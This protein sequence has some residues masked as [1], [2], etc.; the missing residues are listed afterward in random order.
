MA[1][2]HGGVPLL[3]AVSPVVFVMTRERTGAITVGFVM[4]ARA[5]GV[6]AVGWC[7]PAGG[8]GMA[9]EPIGG[10]PCWMDR[11]SLPVGALSPAV[12]AVAARM[13]ASARAVGA[14]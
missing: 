5:M 3:P 6:I 10:R 2:F 13:G 1:L 14:S 8:R 4:A 12:G 9:Q 7:E 11:V